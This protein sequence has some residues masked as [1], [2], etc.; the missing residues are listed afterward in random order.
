MKFYITKRSNLID[1]DGSSLHDHF[2]ILN[3]F[4]CIKKC[5][6]KFDSLIKKIDNDDNIVRKETV[7]NSSNVTIISEYRKIEIFKFLENEYICIEIIQ[8]DENPNKIFIE[9]GVK[10]FSGK[11]HVI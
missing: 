11:V 4:D 6:K 1:C 8:T 2:E 7:K 9:D 10:N 5:K 3:T